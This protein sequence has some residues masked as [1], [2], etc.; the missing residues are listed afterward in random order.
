MLAC[1]AIVVLDQDFAVAM[2]DDPFRVRLNLATARH[3][4]SESV[5]TTE[6]L[7]DL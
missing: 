2:L 7:L 1:V 5:A 4:I 6:E 3:T